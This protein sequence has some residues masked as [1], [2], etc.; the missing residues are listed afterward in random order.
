M[1]YARPVVTTAWSGNTDFTNEE[2]AALVGYDLIVA[3]REYWPYPSGT[4]WAE[5]RLDQAARQMR[6]VWEDVEWRR[7]IGFNAAKT[8]ALQLS[9]EAVG[10]LMK[11]RLDRLSGRLRRNFGRGPSADLPVIADPHRE[12]LSIG[13]VARI[14]C[15]DVARRPLFYAARFWRIPSIILTFGLWHSL[16]LAA[17]TTRDRRIIAIAPFTLKTLLSKVIRLFGRF[18]PPTVRKKRSLDPDMPADSQRHT[19]RKPNE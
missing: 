12:S 1:A 3:D 16:Q 15:V 18:K 9:P 6:R 4:L 7:K 2:N 8:I 10:T 19:D 14:L 11:A 17:H 5:P 13:A